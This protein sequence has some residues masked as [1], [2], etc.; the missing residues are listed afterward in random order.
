MAVTCV[1]AF[2]HWVGNTA[3]LT[4]AIS[5]LASFLAAGCCVY[6]ASQTHGAARWSW[7]LFGSTMIMW[8]SADVLWF[9]D[10]VFDAFHVFMPV[11]NYL[12]LLGLV[13][14]VAGL[15]LFPVGKWEKGAGLRLVLDALVLGAALL[16]VSHLM[17]LREVVER[18]ASTSMR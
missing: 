13:P 7:S 1:L 6:A 15:L 8:T 3:A 5:T 11:T 18:G 16:L 14:V 9:L 17:V 4:D 2:G 12:Y 10:G